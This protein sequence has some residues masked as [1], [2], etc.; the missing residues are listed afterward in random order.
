M[1]IPFSELKLYLSA[2]EGKYIPSFVND[3]A[4]DGGLRRGLV[5][6]EA[7]NK[8]LYVLISDGR[9]VI[10]RVLGF[11]DEE[12]LLSDIPIDGIFTEKSVDLYLYSI[13]NDSVFSSLTDFS[14]I[15]SLFT[16]PVLS[17]M[18]RNLFRRFQKIRKM[19]CFASNTD[20]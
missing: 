12:D 1:I 14:L 9:A 10:S 7:G 19:R 8:T 17:L 5:A 6:A 13:E 18:F 3:L 4:R 2:F 20:Q 11:S 16:L 15:R